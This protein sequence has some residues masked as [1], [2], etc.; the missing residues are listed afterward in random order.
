MKNNNSYNNA[1]MTLEEESNIYS[2]FTTIL[3]VILLATLVLAFYLSFLSPES[4]EFISDSFLSVN[5]PIGE[6]SSSDSMFVG[7]MR[8][9]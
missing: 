4:K 8:A 1:E 5:Y 3:S 6:L 9:Y 2:I 7:K